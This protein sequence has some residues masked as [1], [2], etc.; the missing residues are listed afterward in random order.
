MTVREFLRAVHGSESLCDE[1]MDKEVEVRLKNPD[2]V[3]V[4]SNLEL[5]T[6]S[7]MFSP[8]F[9]NGRGNIVIEAQFK[10]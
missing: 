2:G 1:C 4:T 5:T 9:D 8:W 7:Y 10:S 6:C 3:E